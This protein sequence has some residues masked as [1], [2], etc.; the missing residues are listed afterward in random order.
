MH[1]F[2]QRHMSMK[3]GH[4]GMLIALH[5]VLVCSSQAGEMAETGASRSTLPT[6]YI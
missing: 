4:F 5:F 1:L 6:A 2:I 3:L